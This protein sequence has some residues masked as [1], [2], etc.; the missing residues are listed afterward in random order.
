MICPP[1]R[2]TAW[3]EEP[4]HVGRQKQH[5]VDWILSDNTGHL[6]FE[7][8]TKRLTLDAK[9]LAD[10]VALQNDIATMA[11]AAVQ[12]Y[13]NIRDALK[14]KT[15]WVPDGLPVF[16]LV[17]TLEDWLIFSPQVDK[18]LNEEV[19]AL[20][21]KVG[22][23]PRF[24]VDMPYTIA[25]VHEFEIAG[26]IVAQVGV[27]EVM[28]GKTEGERRRWSLLPFLYSEF[29]EEMRHVNWRLFDGEWKHGPAR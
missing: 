27:C 22:V 1:P 6:F 21:A 13:Q 29:S 23:P 2:F 25:S 15:E 9:T 4:Y 18:A 14:G 26:Q 11:K 12:H 16:P 19:R 10:P 28:R 5:G 3:A 17:L 7:C 8:K 24:L 20:M